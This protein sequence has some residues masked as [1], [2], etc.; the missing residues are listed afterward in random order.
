[1]KKIYL[2]INFHPDDSNKKLIEDISDAL[3]RIDIEAYCMVRDY[4]KWGEI[5][6]SPEECMQKAFEVID[7]SD[8]VIVELSEKGVGIGIEAGYAF[9]QNKPIIVIAKTGSDISST[10]VGIAENVIFYDSVEELSEK[11]KVI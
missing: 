8:A 9:A 1:M 6:L 11:V 4:E 7:S 5:K 3:K 10:L 2:A